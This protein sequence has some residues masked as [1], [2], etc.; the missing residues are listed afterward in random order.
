[1]VAFE[2]RPDSQCIRGK[3]VLGKGHGMF[4]GPEEETHVTRAQELEG[5]KVVRKAGPDGVDHRS[6]FIM[7]FGMSTLKL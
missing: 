3:S 1:M 4:K 7:H 6:N 2:L 5:D